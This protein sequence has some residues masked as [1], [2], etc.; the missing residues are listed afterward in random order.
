[1]SLFANNIKYLR[2]QKNRSQ[3]NVADDLAITRARYSKYEE[4][5]SEPPLNLLKLIATYFLVNI[6][7]LVSVDL[8]KHSIEDLLKLENNRILL[9]VAVD[10]TGG[11][12]IELVPQKAKAGYLNSYSDPEFIESLQHIS[13]PFL[14]NGKFRAFPIEGDSMPP[15]NDGAIIIGKFI[16]DLNQIKSGKTYVIL[17]ADEGII[18]KRVQ[19]NSLDEF[20]LHSDNPSYKQYSVKR[21]DIVEIWEYACS[22]ST[23]DLQTEDLTFDSVKS[24]FRDLKRDISMLSKKNNR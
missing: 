22:I 17:T 2:A 11:N 10:K 20:I 15:H 18:Y 12:L 7:L 4:G 6:D 16:E 1:M 8:K 9:P 19:K 21:S 24:M 5:A 14:K 3:Q 13:F 23:S